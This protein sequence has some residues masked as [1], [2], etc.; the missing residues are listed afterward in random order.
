M[1][2]HECHQD[3]PNHGQGYCSTCY[4]RLRRQGKLDVKRYNV[5]QEKAGPDCGICHRPLL[6][7]SATEF[8]RLLIGV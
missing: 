4:V 3:K 6:E 5:V 1:T 7:H 8:C 2:C